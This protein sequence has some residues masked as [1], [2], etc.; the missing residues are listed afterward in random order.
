MFGIFR[1]N[2]IKKPVLRLPIVRDF[3]SYFG[4]KILYKSQEYFEIMNRKTKYSIYGFKS[5][6]TFFDIMIKDNRIYYIGLNEKSLL[7]E[8]A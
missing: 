1:K 2:T 6:H 8:A 4:N 5:H 7:Q 3:E